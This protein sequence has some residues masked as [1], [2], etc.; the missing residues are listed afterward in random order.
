MITSAA[1]LQTLRLVLRWRKSPCDERPQL[2]KLALHEPAARPWIST[3]PTAVASTGPASTRRPVR[4]AVSWQ[5]SVFWLPPPTMCTVLIFS[6]LSRS[7]SS[8]ALAYASA[9]LSRMLRANTA[10]ESGG[11]AMTSAH[12]A[13][14]RLGMSPGGSRLG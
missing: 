4:L 8:I 5:S 11:A 14:I 3:L 1:G 12:S 2:G 10:G 9:R 6:P 7:A 13:A